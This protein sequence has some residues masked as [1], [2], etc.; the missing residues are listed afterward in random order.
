MARKR[1]EN[2]QLDMTPMIDVVFEL[3]IFFVVTLTEA[4][5]KDETIELESG[6]H[7]IVLTPEELP[8]DHMQIDIAS[9]GKDGKRLKTPRIS[10]GD[11]EM[12]KDEVYARVKARHDKY[13]REF[14]VLIRADFETPHSAVRDV[15]DAC[16]KAG[17]WRLSFMAVREDKTNERKRLKRRRGN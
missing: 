12:T 9:V 11:R 1:Q 2:P 6:R 17:I 5:K 14:P 3:I 15:M 7:G 10:M 13:N 4:Q 16:A 8:P